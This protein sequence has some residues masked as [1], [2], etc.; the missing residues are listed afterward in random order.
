M[1]FNA[2]YR[3]WTRENWAGFAPTISDMDRRSWSLTLTCQACRLS[4]AAD[5]KRIIRERGPA[6]SPWGRSAQCP[7]LGCHGRMRMEA[8]DPRS[9]FK[10]DV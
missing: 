2:K 1:G 10:I 9:G 8:Y 3:F 6:W 4:I 7:R 5:P